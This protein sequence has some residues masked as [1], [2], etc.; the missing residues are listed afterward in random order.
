MPLE[1]DTLPP[2]PAQARALAAFEA[3]ASEDEH[4]ARLIHAAARA[5]VISEAEAGRRLERLAEQGARSA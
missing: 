2:P 3:A 4:G 1:P 5:G